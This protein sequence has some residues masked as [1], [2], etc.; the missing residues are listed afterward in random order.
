M[1]YNSV[2]VFRGF[3]NHFCVVEQ[4]I[5][6]ALS[7][8][9][10]PLLKNFHVTHLQNEMLNLK[11]D[12]ERLQRIVTSKSLTSSQSSLPIT[13]SLERR[14]SMTETSTPP[15][16][17]LWFEHHFTSNNL[18][19][20]WCILL[21]LLSIRKTKHLCSQLYLL[22]YPH[23]TTTCFHNCEHEPC[24]ADPH[25]WQTAVHIVLHCAHLPLPH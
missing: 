5:Y 11:Q 16:T 21:H 7:S 15:P 23:F 19:L 13:D 4:D 17:G 8:T 25:W 24:L 2:L 3:L 10:T 9:V 6:K 14:F 12:N 20:V 18:I 22:Y 1:I